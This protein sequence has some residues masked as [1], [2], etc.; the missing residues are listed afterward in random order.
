MADTHK[1][2]KA[3]HANKA[4]AAATRAQIGYDQTIGQALAEGGQRH[5]NHRRML[6]K[7]KVRTRRNDRLETKDET[8]QELELELIQEEV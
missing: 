2:Q 3:Y 8:R 7:E 6:A 5:G 1:I 4:A